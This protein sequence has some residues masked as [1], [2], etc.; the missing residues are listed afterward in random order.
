MDDGLTSIRVAITT[1]FGRNVDACVG[2]MSAP[3]RVAVFDGSLANGRN[4][5][6]FLIAAF[7]A[8]VS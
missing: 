7:L 2:R 4:R 3:G 1:Y 5:R 8:K 6:I